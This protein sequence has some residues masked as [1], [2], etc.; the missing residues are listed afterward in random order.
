MVVKPPR[1]YDPVYMNIFC[2][3]PLC[4]Y[5]TRKYVLINKRKK[6]SMIFSGSCVRRHFASCYILL[7]LNTWYIDY[8]LVLKRENK[9]SR[10]LS[11]F[12]M[13]IISTLVLYI[14]KVYS[15]SSSAKTSLTWVSSRRR[16]EFWF[17]IW[18]TS[19]LEKDAD[20]WSWFSSV[21][22]PLSGCVLGFL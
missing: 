12:Y 22:C 20:Q 1:S 7:C 14:L 17:P 3:M 4:E 18:S 10:L 8:I 13:S 11:V 15:E 16:L 21:S 5:C 19:C 6:W 2:C 9:L